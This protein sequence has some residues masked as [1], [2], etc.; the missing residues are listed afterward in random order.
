MLDY[1]QQHYQVP[2]QPKAEIE[3]TSDYSNNAFGGLLIHE[4]ISGVSACTNQDNI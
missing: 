1:H 4:C 2:T 3:K